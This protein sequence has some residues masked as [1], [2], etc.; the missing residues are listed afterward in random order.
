MNKKYNQYV[1]FVWIA[2]IAIA[3]LIIILCTKDLIAEYT[4]TQNA[5]SRYERQVQE[6][7]KE[8]NAIDAAI[9]EEKLKLNS[10]KPIYETDIDSSSGNLGIFGNMFERLVRRAQS[11]G[12]MIRS[13]EYNMNPMSDPLYAEHSDIYNA[14]E[15]KFF[16]VGTYSQLQSFLSE[17]SNNFEYLIYI[18][19]LSVS[20][21]SKNTDYLLINTSITLYSKKPES[22]IKRT[23]SSSAKRSEKATTRK[24]RR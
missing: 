10:L 13:I 2:A 17:V 23:S 4:E 22:E 1:P 11:N 20:A 8:V 15:L 5:V 21:F 9:R 19:K 24:R 18:S 7:E 3:I 6:K 16:F 14:C 12:L